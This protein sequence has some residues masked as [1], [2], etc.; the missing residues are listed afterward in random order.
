MISNRV[1]PQSAAESVRRGLGAAMSFRSRL[2][3]PDGRARALSDPLVY[4][5]RGI[6][7]RYRAATNRS[8]VRSRAGYDNRIGNSTVRRAKADRRN[9]R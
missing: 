4:V 3:S 5:N 2:V 8:R 7:S 6:Y 9:A 1:I